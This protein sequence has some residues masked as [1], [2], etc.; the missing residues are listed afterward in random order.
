MPDEGHTKH[1]FWKCHCV[2]FSF[3]GHTEDSTRE[4][5]CS[6]SDTFHVP[7]PI[8][9]MHCAPSRLALHTDVY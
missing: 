3:A 8:L 6:F 9:P 1:L 2:L 4:G 7:A 5:Q